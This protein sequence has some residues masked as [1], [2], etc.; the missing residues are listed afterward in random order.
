MFD[1]GVHKILVKPLASN[2]NT[3]N[4]I[5]VGSGFSLLHVIPTTSIGVFP[6]SS[7]K[8][9]T[10]GSPKNIFRADVSFSWMSP[11][12]QLF[13][14][15]D[16]K[17]VYYAGHKEVRLSGFI[18]GSEVDLSEWMDVSKNGRAKGRFLFLGITSSGNVIGFLAIPG[19][20]ISRQVESL[21]EQNKCGFSKADKQGVFYR[22]DLVDAPPDA[23]SL[24]Q[25]PASLDDESHPDASSRAR[26]TKKADGGMSLG[27]LDAISNEVQETTSRGLLLKQLKI[28]HQNGC[29]KSKKLTDGVL[30]ACNAPNCGGLTLEAELGVS[31][32]GFAEPDYLGWEV[33]SYSGSVI[34]LMTPEPNG[35]DYSSLSIEEFIRKYGYPDRSGIP[36]RIN[37]GGVHKYGERHHLTGLKMDI[38]G[39]DVES[40]E[41]IDASGELALISDSQ[42]TALS[43]SFS[44]LLEHWKKKHAQAVYV[45]SKKGQ[46]ISGERCYSYGNMVTLGEGTDFSMF[47]R[48]IVGG[49]VYY[50]PGIKLENASSASPVSKK[51]SQ[52]RVKRADLSGLYRTTVEIDVLRV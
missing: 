52:I 21:S 20:V 50:D 29:I 40:G 51:R 18:A 47:L 45:R 39:F 43:W 34:T 16:A 1:H 14:A 26:D 25:E 49:S 22:I 3:K 28:V 9:I 48:A 2:D 7:A 12:G 10:E 35:G 31:Q 15:P 6:S 41:L 4:Q 30:R 5:Y 32:N 44:K 11:R 36:D 42:D 13:P 8:R 38:A 23:S 27:E 17:L 37:F 24:W 46:S 33:K 19:G